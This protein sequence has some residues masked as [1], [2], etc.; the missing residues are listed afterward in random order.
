M[1]T[2][3]HVVGGEIQ[4]G[5][6]V[7]IPELHE[8]IVRNVCIHTTIAPWFFKVAL[9]E[10]FQFFGGVVAL[11]HPQRHRFVRTLDVSP[12]TT[13]LDSPLVH[14]A[15]QGQGGDAFTWCFYLVLLPGLYT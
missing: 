14:T 5:V 13:A 6:G 3:L 15:E 11:F 1:I 7:V 9:N 2:F 10:S 8:H 4:Q 12:T